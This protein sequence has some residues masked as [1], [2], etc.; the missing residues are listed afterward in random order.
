M[1]G[2]ALASSTQFHDLGNISLWLII[3]KSNFINAT[4][5]T[6]LILRN[7]F[8]YNKMVTV[9]TREVG[10]FPFSTASTQSTGPTQHPFHWFPR[11]LFPDAK[12]P[13][14]ETDH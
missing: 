2:A 13:D 9:K 5:E 11:I 14:R 10:D 7:C 4:T 6:I 3:V 12:L 8:N 1:G